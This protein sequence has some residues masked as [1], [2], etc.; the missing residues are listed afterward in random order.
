MLDDSGSAPERRPIAIA[1]AG[2]AQ[3]P[4]AL[5]V[6][7]MCVQRNVNAAGQN[8]AVDPAGCSAT[9][10]HQEAAAQAKLAPPPPDY[11]SP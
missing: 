9:R 10:P 11:P 5:E 6:A 2:Q 4:S 8:I 3:P 1:V 7:G